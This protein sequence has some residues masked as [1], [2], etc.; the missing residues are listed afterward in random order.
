MTAFVLATRTSAS[1]S[2]PSSHRF[3]TK[4]IQ[5]RCSLRILVRACRVNNICSPSNLTY[6]TTKYPWTPWKITMTRYYV[7]RRSRWT[8]QRKKILCFYSCWRNTITESGVWSPRNYLRHFHTGPGEH[9]TS[10]YNGGR[11]FWILKLSKVNGLRKKIWCF[12]RQYSTART[13][14]GKI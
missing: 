13:G 5:L 6:F 9:Q 12:A 8:G 14:P 2:V 1:L 3:W 10:A 11:G 4:H 7:K